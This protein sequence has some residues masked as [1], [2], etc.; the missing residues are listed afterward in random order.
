MGALWYDGCNKSG[1]ATK[2]EDVYACTFYFH[3][4]ATIDEKGQKGPKK[5]VESRLVEYFLDRFCESF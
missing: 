4:Y 3:S 5:Y 1:S 2:V